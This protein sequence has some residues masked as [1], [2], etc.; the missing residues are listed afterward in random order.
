[1]NYVV[2]NGINSRYIRG[3]LVQELPPITKPK[4]R[5]SIEEIDGKDGDVITE[6]G[7]AAYDKSVKIGLFGDYDIDAVI[8]FFNT[9]GT[10]IFSNEPDK[11]YYFRTLDEIDFERLIRFRTATVKLHVQP[12]K[13]SA[14]D[15]ALTVPG[16]AENLTVTNQGNT[17]ARPT[18]EIKGSGLIT[19]SLNGTAIL[20][21]SMPD[22]GDITINSEQL[23]AYND[24]G[25]QN[26][27]VIGDYSKFILNHG[28][29]VIAWDG[30][31]EEI[32][33]S[34]YSRWI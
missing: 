12:F 2:I 19:I 22:S 26:R 1:M 10:V 9:A 17:N 13:Y 33:V 5:A 24:S 20:K 6:L 8:E 3:L 11:F 27:R 30:N 32:S 15:G 18:I 31:V 28:K 14:I 25:Y 29:N 21:I 7:Y 16:N 34:K 23:E 4:M